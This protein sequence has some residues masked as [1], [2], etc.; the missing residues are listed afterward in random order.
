VEHRIELVGTFA[1]VRYYNDSKA[2]NPDSTLKALAAFEEPIVLIAGGRAKG[3]DLEPLLR[4]IRQR[5]QHVVVIGETAAELER[6]IRERPG[7]P[8]ER[9]GDLRAAVRAAA[10]AASPGSVVL[11]SPAFASYDMFDN[12]EDRGRRFKEAVREEL[13]G[14]H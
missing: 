6:R 10:A 14:A 4:A 3:A 13:V 1:G 5:V 7:P 2:T 12:Y 9:A 11:L 8:V